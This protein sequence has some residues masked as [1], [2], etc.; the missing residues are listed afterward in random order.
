MTTDIVI[1]R[2]KE[3]RIQRNNFGKDGSV[4]DDGLI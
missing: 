1:T 3:I 2:G 4:P